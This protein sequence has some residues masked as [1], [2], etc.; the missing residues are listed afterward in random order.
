MKNKPKLEG[1]DY[2]EQML[3]WSAFI[4]GHPHVGSALREVLAELYTLREK[5]GVK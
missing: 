3:N 5:D 1:A 2:L 4:N